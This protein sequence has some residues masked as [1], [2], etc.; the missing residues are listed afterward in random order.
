MK[1]YDVIVAG[2]G[3]AG[4]VAAIAAAGEGASVLAVERNTYAGGS[5]TGGFVP[6]YYIQQPVGLMKRIDELAH[7][8]YP[9]DGYWQSLTEIKKHELEKLAV[10]RGVEIRYETAV[11]GVLK[12]GDR[13]TGV[14]CVCNGEISE[15]SAAVVIDC[16]ADAIVCRMAGCE[17]RAGR[18]RDGQFMPF[19]NSF[20]RSNSERRGT[21]V[22]NFDA[23]RIDQT[24]EPE[25]SRTMLNTVLVHLHD[26]YSEHRSLCAPSD[27][28]GI[29]EGHK[30]VPE[31]RMATLA[32]VLDGEQDASEAIGFVWSNL[33]THAN[34]MPLESELIQDWMIGAS[35]WGIQL[36]FA[37]PRNAL[38]PKGVKG[39][40]AAARH[41]GVGHDMAY[42]L[43]MNTLMG[44]IGEAA[45]YIAALAAKRGVD[46]IA[47]PYADFAGKLELPEKP[48]EYNASLWALDDDAIRAG[49]DSDKPGYAMWA[50]RR[51]VP[52]EKLEKWYDSAAPGGNLRRHLAF[53]LA[54]KDSAYGAAELRDAV[55]ER[56]EFQPTHSRKYNHFRGYVALYF[57]GKLADPE[58]VELCAEVLADQE[59]NHK[60]EY[61]SNALIALFKIGRHHPE[62]RRRVSEII[63]ATLEDPAWQ[64][65]SRLKGTT[66]TLKRMD[67]VF[68]CAA[69]CELRG[70]GVENHIAE[71][72]LANHPDAYERDLAER[73]GVIR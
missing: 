70:W 41:L 53:T 24:R 52:V 8:D 6:S 45:G 35:M 58:A 64:I 32:D 30:I 63:R 48:L 68:R 2:F 27:L 13:V 9:Q 7:T 71:A 23:G 22:A 5:H 28:P 20:C 19:T 37:V 42:A 25:F 55:R 26:D 11:I 44:F 15:Y 3:T 38:I 39:L 50:A 65:S 73:L 56:D 59:I 16:T 40:M 18:T 60:Y 47:V 54:L 46:P 61:H 51:N 62:T 34:D 49:L 1:K 10:E 72:L 14:R 4:A 33:D 36:W 29:R 69:A 12:T 57:L 66:D 17:T 67:A 43:R 31:G 21:Y